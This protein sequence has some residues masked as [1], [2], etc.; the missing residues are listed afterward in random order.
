MLTDILTPGLRVAICGTAVAAASA[1]RG[2]YYSGPGNDFWRL[3]AVSAL[4][5][6]ELDPSEDRSLPTYGVGLTD[7]VK[8]LAQSHDRG[9]TYDVPDLDRRLSAVRPAWLAFHGKTAGNAV[10]RAGDHRVV[11]LGQQPWRFAGCRVFVLPSASGANRRS[12]YDGKATRDEWWADFG[13][14]VL[15]DSDGSRD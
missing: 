8:N 12:S 15:N 13:R 5:P 6:R 7:L 4:V 1:S 3:L 11:A 2:H 10:A 14:A 9:L